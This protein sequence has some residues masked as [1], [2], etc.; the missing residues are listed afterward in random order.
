MSL[1]EK[2]ELALKSIV[3]FWQ[4][5]FPLDDVFPYPVSLKIRLNADRQCL[6]LDTRRF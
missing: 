3:W 6:F 2:K 1:N 4:S 5:K